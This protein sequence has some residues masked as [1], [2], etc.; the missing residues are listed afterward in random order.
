MQ[1]DDCRSSFAFGEL[2]TD[3]CMQSKSKFYSNFMLILHALVELRWLAMANRCWGRII[4]LE[5]EAIPISVYAKSRRV[6]V[7]A[8]CAVGFKFFWLRH[9]G[10]SERNRIYGAKEKSDFILS[11]SKTRNQTRHDSLIQVTSSSPF[12]RGLTARQCNGTEKLVSLSAAAVS[13]HAGPGCLDI[14]NQF[15][16]DL[17][18]TEGN[19]V[20][21]IILL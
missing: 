12:V 11:K 18:F 14:A 2:D 8:D 19:A 4:I 3:L 10:I 21:V 7:G 20:G 6:L 1:I 17:F 15:S 16:L 9:R 13:L 5:L